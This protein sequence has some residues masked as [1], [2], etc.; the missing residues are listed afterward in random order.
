MT[1][2]SVPTQNVRALPYGEVRAVR[3]ALPGGEDVH[4]HQHHHVAYP[5]GRDEQA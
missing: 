1:N 5:R 2:T 4:V 3:Q